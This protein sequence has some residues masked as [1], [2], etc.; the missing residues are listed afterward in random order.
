MRHESCLVEDCTTR[1]LIQSK[2]ETTFGRWLASSQAVLRGFEEPNDNAT[3][4]SLLY[5]KCVLVCLYTYI[6][7]AVRPTHGP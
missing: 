7:I 5:P 6:Y 2:H 4:S 1:P 3:N